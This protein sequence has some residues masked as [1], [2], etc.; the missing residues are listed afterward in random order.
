MENFITRI[1][2]SFSAEISTKRKMSIK[3]REEQAKKAVE[4]ARTAATENQQRHAA[5]GPGGNNFQAFIQTTAERYV[6]F[7]AE[8]HQINEILAPRGANGRGGNATN[9]AE[10]RRSMFCCS[11]L[12]PFCK[13]PN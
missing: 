3:E 10:R 1:F 13:F 5:A 7:L 12:D 11:F 8:L 2:E 6:D 9:N 4:D